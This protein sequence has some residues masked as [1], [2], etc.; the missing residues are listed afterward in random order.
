M[1]ARTLT[2]VILVFVGWP[3]LLALLLYVAEHA[4]DWRER[5]R[6]RREAR[7]ELDS[8]VNDYEAHRR[9]DRHDG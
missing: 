2:E 9:D 8:L 6:F 7:A 5:R 1:D 4:G 3:L